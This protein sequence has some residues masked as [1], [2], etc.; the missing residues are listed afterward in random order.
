M[1]LRLLAGIAFNRSAEHRWR[2]VAVSVS[3]L[4]S[5]I[6][7][8]TALGVL[9]LVAATQ[10]RGDARISAISDRERESDVVALFRG[11]SW[12]GAAI[13]TMWFA[14]IN[15]NG[16][17]RTGPGVSST[18]EPGG[19]LVSPA[20]DRLIAERPELRSRFPQRAV[21]DWDG[22]ADSNELLAYRRLP[23]GEP[24]ERAR[25]SV[26][27]TAVGNA[28]TS[29]DAD[30]LRL[31]RLSTLSKP[32]TV[33]EVPLLAGVLIFLVVPGMSILVT[34]LGANSRL[35]HSRFEL[36]GKL[37]VSHRSLRRF[38]VLEGV[39]VAVPG[40]L[41]ACLL[42]EFTSR[43]LT[44]LPGT[45][46]LLAPGDLE[47]PLWQIGTTSCLIAVLG[48]CLT[49]GLRT[50]R[51]ERDAGNALAERPLR[52]WYLIPLL[53][54]AAFYFWSTFD[55]VADLYTL[56]PAVLLAVVGT[57]LACLFLVRN[58]G[59]R[60]AESESATVQVV[61]SA[62]ARYPRRVSRPLLGL[63]VIATAVLAVVGWSA[64]ALHEELPRTA[65][66]AFTFAEIDTASSSDEARLLGNPDG[67][68]VSVLAARI[69]G[70]DGPTASEP[71]PETVTLVATCADMRRLDA[72]F[73]CAG[74]VVGGSFSE[75]L[76]RTFEGAYPIQVGRIDW[77]P[78]S[79]PL[80]ESDQL[81]ALGREDLVVFDSTVRDLVAADAPAGQVVTRLNLQL[82]PNPLTY[83]IV[84]G[85]VAALLGL[86]VAFMIGFVD[87]QLGDRSD[88]EQIVSIGV[89]RRTVAMLDGLGLLVP[90]VTVMAA[91]F[92]VGLLCCRNFLNLETPFPWSSVLLVTALTCLFAVVAASLAVA[93]G[94]R[95]TFQVR[96]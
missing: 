23:E 90:F 7:I 81:V 45:D 52:R 85:V 1:K 36:L 39:L 35:R 60:F 57:P 74:P 77:H 71:K 38:A 44:S 15:A 13:E 31:D 89:K 92:P 94:Q 9:H 14:P 16:G 64:V 55:I 59:G 76:T 63:S 4:L 20:L 21:L 8:L 53:A 51:G 83:W 25:Q 34:G 48:S 54:S 67:R 50:R 86:C 32:E 33:P 87:R 46:R 82:H 3:S 19:S 26:Q 10:E 79:D 22:V 75:R 88:R 58:W 24:A 73:T 37:G 2:L 43:S 11:D 30:F 91:A 18:V 17:Y 61:G 5:G 84:A 41:G 12:E 95:T 68:Q 65:P 93:L 6:L 29:S 78:L 27:S 42:Y 66:D 72:G 47:L 56:Y 49:V 62:M 96:D 80:I 69:A 70:L 40:L 28:A